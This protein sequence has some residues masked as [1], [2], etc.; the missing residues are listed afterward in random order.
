MTER[1]PRE[2]LPTCQEVVEVI[3]NYL[4]DRMDVVER[5][6]FER[7]LAIC[8]GC[9]TYLEQIRVTIRASS[10]LA[11]E[12]IPESQRDDLIKAFRELFPA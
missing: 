6:R 2:P 7:H 9:A 10:A 11:D 1:K 4:E 5:E 12:A 8:E 3:T